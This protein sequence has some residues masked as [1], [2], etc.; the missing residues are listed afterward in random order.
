MIDTI[1]QF[2]EKLGVG[3]FTPGTDTYQPDD[4]HRMI[5]AEKEG[6]PV[7]TYDSFVAGSWHPMGSVEIEPG[8]GFWVRVV[9]VVRLYTGATFLAS[10]EVVAS[11]AFG[12]EGAEL[13]TQERARDKMILP[14]A[15]PKA[16]ARLP[17]FEGTIKSKRS[18][19]TRKEVED[20]D[21]NDSI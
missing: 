12:L 15:K 10:D 17:D 3:R 11:V 18:A 5:L 21:L 7:F 19:K 8:P 4:N 14:R 16:G 9:E 20:E 13:L 6:H 1:K 2:V